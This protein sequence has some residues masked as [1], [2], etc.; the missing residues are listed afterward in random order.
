MCDQANLPFFH[1]MYDIPFLVLSVQHFF[2]FHTIV[3]IDPHPSQAPY[4]KTFKVF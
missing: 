2:I 1:C 3:P 4:L